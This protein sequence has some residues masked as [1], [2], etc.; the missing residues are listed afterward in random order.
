MKATFSHALLLVTAEEKSLA[1]IRNLSD[2]H[3]KALG[4]LEVK[5]LKANLQETIA[6]EDQIIND[7]VAKLEDVRTGLN[8]RDTEP[9][10]IKNRVPSTGDGAG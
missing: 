9:E 5:I 10:D 8:Q 7:Q 6:E 3:R 2:D 1:R 4:L